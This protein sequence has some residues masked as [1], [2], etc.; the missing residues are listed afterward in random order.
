M[1]RVKNA[2]RI[3][4]NMENMDAHCL[5]GEAISQFEDEDLMQLVQTLKQCQEEKEQAQHKLQTA[6]RDNDTKEDYCIQKAEQVV[7]LCNTLES[8]EKMEENSR[9]EDPLKQAE[10]MSSF[11]QGLYQS[12]KHGIDIE[13]LD[14]VSVD[15]GGN[16]VEFSIKFSENAQVRVSLRNASD[17][18]IF[19]TDKP[20]LARCK[21]VVIKKWPDISRPQAEEILTSR[22]SN[23]EPLACTVW[24]LYELVK[25]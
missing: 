13:I 22:K 16:P 3:L 24:K 4:E 21:C 9:E 6:E 8:L 12:L 7:K 15:K 17:L 20:T 5:A 18:E 1:E 2:T 25:P 10:K 14:D 19:V 11:Y 23:E